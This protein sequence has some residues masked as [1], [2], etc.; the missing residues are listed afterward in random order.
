MAS[1]CPGGNGAVAPCNEVLFEADNDLLL[2]DVESPVGVPLAGGTVSVEIFDVEDLGT[3]LVG[4]LAL[5][6]D[7]G[8][9]YS[10]EFKADAGSG[11]FVGQRIK[12]VYD[13]DG[14]GVDDDRIFNV[15]AIVCEG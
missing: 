2:S 14:P 7:G 6:D 8:G 13:F 5:G 11:F 3:V 15:I 10:G 9:D 1:L 4:P 12:I